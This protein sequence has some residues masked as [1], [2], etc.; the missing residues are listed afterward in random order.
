VP[1]VGVLSVVL[2]G[3]ALAEQLLRCQVIGRLHGVPLHG[4]PLS[5]LPRSLPR[6]TLNPLD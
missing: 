3:H 2:E 6:V 4:R 5:I 1:A